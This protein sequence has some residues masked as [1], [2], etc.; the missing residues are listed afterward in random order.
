MAEAAQGDVDSYN[1]LLAAASKDIAI[2]VYGIDESSQALADMSEY[3]QSEDFKDIEVGMSIDDQ[4][5]YD[6][7]NLMIAQ[8][9]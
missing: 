6:A 1:E 9:N 5:F 7:L 3:L 4:A 8:G 2:N